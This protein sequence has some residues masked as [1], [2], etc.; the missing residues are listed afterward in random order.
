MRL[1]LVGILAGGF[2]F[3]SESSFSQSQDSVIIAKLNFK[4]LQQYLSTPD[5]SVALS[6]KALALAE[7]KGSIKQQAF[8]YYVLSRAQWAKSNYQLSTKYA[9]KSLKIYENS[10]Q[11]YHWGECLITLGRTFADLKDHAL[12]DQYISK[13]F[14]LARK[15]NHEQLM[16]EVMRE[17]S[18][19]FLEQHKYDSALYCINRGIEIYNKFS[20]SLN[21]SVL[22]ERKARLLFEQ[23]KLSESKVYI[24]RSLQL[25]SLVKNQR[26]LGITLY[27]AGLIEWKSGNT[28]KALNFLN[29]S[30]LVNRTLNNIQNTIKVRTLL[31]EI[32]LSKKLSALAVEELQ[33]VSVL[34][35]SLY[36]VEKNVKVQE[37]QAVYELEEKEHQILLLENE[38]VIE[39]KTAQNQK[40]LLLSVSTIMVL[41]AL[42]S[43][44]FWRM[45]GGQLDLNKALATKN[46]E[47]ELQNEEIQA[48]SESLHQINQL[49]SK[50][51]SVISHDLRG[52]IKN[53]YMLLEM[54][55][56]KIVTPEEFAEL[57][58]KLKSNLNVTQRTLENLLNWSMGQMEG[59]KTDPVSFNINS[60][61]DD[62]AHLSEEAA[63]HK[64]LLVKSDSKNPVFVLAD[65]NQVHLILR[66]LFNNAIKF[67]QR[68][69]EVVITTEI[70][71]QFCFISIQD[72]GIGMTQAEV[73]MI[74]NTNEYFTKVGTDQEKGTG[75][76]LLLCKDFIKRNGGAFSI[77]SKLKEGTR[78]TFSLPLG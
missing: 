50:L 44:L 12:A 55:T 66:N 35:D 69:G 26:G 4:A 10:A 7:Q 22:Y 14:V 30:L 15:H 38:N 63:N 21:I 43:Y 73:D 70:K 28:D 16:A 54:V 8:S 67:S 77:S 46:Q 62:V 59:I 13:G 75:L 45:R 65:V 19:L 36:S 39:K 18:F 9:F 57:S 2:F 3:H 31:A 68:D 27:Q 64:Q 11:I 5:S 17:K 1:I 37:M 6:E 32:Y 40:I 52:P 23:G 49:K 72:N 76:G 61:I 25:D 53:L 34:K 33:K 58:V 74:L 56:K 29:K 78:V 48:Q 20:D 71:N 42:L 60:V 24:N 51:L 41:L 47:I